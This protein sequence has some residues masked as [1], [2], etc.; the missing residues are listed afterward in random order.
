LILSKHKIIH[1]S[2]RKYEK[3]M[4]S[5]ALAQKGVLYAKIMVKDK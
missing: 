4:D 5:D 2:F 3:S 1:K